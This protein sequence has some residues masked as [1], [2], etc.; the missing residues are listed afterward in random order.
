MEYYDGEAERLQR[1]R[2]SFWQDPWNIFEWCSLLLV[3][4]TFILHIVNIAKP[5]RDLFKGAKLV[6]A[7]S[8]LLIWFRLFKTLRI[9]KIFAELTVLLGKA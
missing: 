8:L 2:S 7:V 6:S 3:V 4:L 1:Q 5:D 9:F